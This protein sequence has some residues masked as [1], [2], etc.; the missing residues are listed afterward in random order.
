[1]NLA[2]N[3]MG[4][5]LYA[6]LLCV[7]TAATGSARQAVSEVRLRPGDQVQLLVTN[8]PALSGRFTITP[9][10]SAMLPLI[11]LI[12]VSDRP[13]DAVERDLRAAFE[14]ELAEPDMVITPL[15]RVAVLGEVRAPAMHWL[16][17]TGTL[18]DLLVL[19]GGLLPTANRNRITLQRDGQAV[20]VAV[21]DFGAI[22]PIPVRSGDRLLVGRR[23]WFSDN[24]AIFVGAAASVA[25]AAVTTLI[26]R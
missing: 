21:D 16:D 26:V 7:A 15:M 2:P 23:S 11:G 8:E 14:V 10:G 5:V 20:A 19:S 12:A 6:L 22:A 25:A 17:P 24:L 13:F 3:P 4:P 18:V 1:M 9:D